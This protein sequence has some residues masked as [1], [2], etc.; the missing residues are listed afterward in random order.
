MPQAILRR[1]RDEFTVGV[2][3]DVLISD[4]QLAH[5]YTCCAQGVRYSQLALAVCPR[6]PALSRE[7]GCVK[8]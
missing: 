5:E 1:V 7:G 4:R 8:V 2:V 3:V 6:Y